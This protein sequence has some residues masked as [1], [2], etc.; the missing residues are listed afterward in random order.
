MAGAIISA[1][2]TYVR[3]KPSKTNIIKN[4][5]KIKT[6]T[7]IYLLPKT[8][9]WNNDELKQREYKNFD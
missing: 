6:N 5:S 3:V 1:F 9:L 7:K 2:S 8:V 4:T